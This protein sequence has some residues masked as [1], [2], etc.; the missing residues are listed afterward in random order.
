MEKGE[1]KLD[2]LEAK[3]QWYSD[4]RLRVLDLYDSK[5][6]IPELKIYSD[7]DL[8]KYLSKLSVERKAIRKA[9]NDLDSKLVD[10]DSKNDLLNMD[11][12]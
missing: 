10:A 7:D 9:V 5:G 12:T 6:S 8:D 2:D 3:K 11:K 1:K 4:E